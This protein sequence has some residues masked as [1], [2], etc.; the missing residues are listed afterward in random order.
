M[1][2]NDS[3]MF[4]YSQRWLIIGGHINGVDVAPIELQDLEILL[5]SEVTI[6]R[7]VGESAFELYSSKY[8][9][10]SVERA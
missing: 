2:A 9:Q 5:D 8:K 4:R 7:D 1:Q 10:L 3:K 6:A